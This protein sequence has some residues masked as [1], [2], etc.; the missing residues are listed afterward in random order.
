MVSL[1]AGSGAAVHIDDEE[2]FGNS[3][4]QAGIPVEVTT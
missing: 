3:C 1:T 4:T 2:A